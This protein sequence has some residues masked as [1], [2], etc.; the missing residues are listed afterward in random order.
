MPKRK[1]VAQ[2]NNSR[3]QVRQHNNWRNWASGAATAFRAGRDIY[4]R[5]KTAKK[6]INKLRTKT[7][8]KKPKVNLKK[9]I[10][11]STAF[12][13][14]VMKTYE[15]RKAQ[16]WSKFTKMLGNKSTIRIQLS[17]PVVN[18]TQNTQF[19]AYPCGMLFS[20]VDV[21][22]ALINDGKFWNQTTGTFVAIN[23]TTSQWNDYYINVSRTNLKYRIINHMPGLT[24]VDIYL[25]VSRVDTNDVVNAP[26]DA[27]QYDLL[28]QANNLAAASA[29]VAETL[30]ESPY[31]P[32]FKRFWRIQKKYTIVLG[33]GCEHYG[34]WSRNVNK[35]IQAALLQATTYC[36]DVTC[37]VMTVQRGCIINDTNSNVGGS[38]SI[39]PTKISCVATATLT[40]N[41]LQIGANLSRNYSTLPTLVAGE[42]V[43]NPDTGAVMNEATAAQIS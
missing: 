35:K 34:V 14:K 5:T 2:I 27:W 31:G 30:D 12:P 38:S 3:R 24:E 9:P 8:H 36:K 33:P 16:K 28:A 20:A 17:N 21:N 40:C 1:A 7:V 29:V 25:L 26:Y 41:M 13:D 39:G 42:F 18:T 4:N 43:T 22:N 23:P 19:I 32:R 11:E 6:F 10:I 15:S 37:C